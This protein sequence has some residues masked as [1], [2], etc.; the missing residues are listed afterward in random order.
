[1]SGLYIEACF[2]QAMFTNGL[3]LGLRRQFR[4]GDTVET[5]LLSGK[6]KIPVQV[7]CKKGHADSRV[8][9][10]VKGETI[11]SSFFLPNLLAIFHIIY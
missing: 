1:M 8:Y 10:F 3:N 11:N 4:I 6:E 9:R 2:C 5:Y 7:V